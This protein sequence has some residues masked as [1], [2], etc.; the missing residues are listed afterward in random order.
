[1]E[2]PWGVASHSC[3]CGTTSKS[4]EW[5]ETASISTCRRTDAP[6]WHLPWKQNQDWAGSTGTVIVRTSS[7]IAATA[8]L[9]REIRTIDPNL[10]VTRT[11]TLESRIDDLAMTQRIGASLLGWFSVVALA[12]AV[13][14]IYGLIAHAV[15]R[16]TKEIGIRTALGAEPRDIVR[17]MMAR[18][19]TPVACGVGIGLG[20]AYLLSRF[21]GR[22]L[23]GLYPHDPM[24]FAVATACLCTA[25]AVATYIPARRA[26]RFAPVRAL[27]TE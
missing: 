1:M 15:A 4:W 14:G 17:L 24:T 11:A 5:R 25:A 6:D 7:P 13:V 18:S 10:P 8:L 19:L 12:L 20:G 3:R 21:A 9:R 2:R 27:R 26:G 16:R 23:F 22:F